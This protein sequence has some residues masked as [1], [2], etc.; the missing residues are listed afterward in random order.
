M[1]KP[2]S[3]PIVVGCEG[4]YHNLTYGWNSITTSTCFAAG[5]KEHH[6]FSDCL[7]LVI[8]RFNEDEV[9]EATF[10][11]IGDRVRVGPAAI[12]LSP[13]QNRAGLEIRRDCRFA[14][15]LGLLH[16][17]NDNKAGWQNRGP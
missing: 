11:A 7:I 15:F 8:V 2:F 1:V 3:C 4:R 14:R 13:A 16:V 6:D 9:T 12:P 5:A 10:E 17:C